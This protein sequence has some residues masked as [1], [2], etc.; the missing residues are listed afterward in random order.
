MSFYPI[1]FPLLRY[2][3]TA[4]IR[5]RFALSLA[6]LIAVAI[7]LSI[8]LGSSA[9]TEQDSFAVVFAAGALRIGGMAAL[10]LFTV[11]YIRRSFD[12]RDIE[13]LLS[14]PIGRISFL[15]S[16]AMALTI[17][18]S[19][20]AAAI[21]ICVAALSPGPLT[22]GH[23]LWGVSILMEY[24]I[25]ANAALFF[26]MVLPGAA[27]SAFAAGGLYVLSRLTGQIFGILDSGTVAGH[28]SW[29]E[30]IM[31]SISLFVPRLDLMGQTAWLLYGIPENG[32]GYGLIFA[33][34]AVFA[35]MFIM[36]AAIDLVRRRF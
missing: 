17:L 11:Y 12:S 33:Q 18:A 20:S 13:Y 2:V 35:S 30:K 31:E 14:R 32:A 26:A 25:M 10:V 8:F 5:D 7:S 24:I 36:A 28:F 21:F 15:F 16:H 9:V 6:L 23:V 29:M 3:L 4:A 19:V 27:T 34:G 22:S 1:S